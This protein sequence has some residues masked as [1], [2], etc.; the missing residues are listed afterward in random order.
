MVI[1]QIIIHQYLLNKFK[2]KALKIYP[3]EHIQAILGKLS[4]DT[5]YINALVDLSGI[6]HIGS[7]DE[8]SVLYER[9]EIEIEYQTGLKYFGNIHSHP[10]G[11]LCHSKTDWH[12]F[13]ESMHLDTIDGGGYQYEVLCEHVMGILQIN[14]LKYGCQF[15]IIFYN[16]ELEQITVL[17]SETKKPKK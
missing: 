3:N 13:H 4:N 10:D 8:V 9:P 6:E 7:G 17:I 1:K 11:P 12:A 16:T 15:G 14:K 5:L 2:R